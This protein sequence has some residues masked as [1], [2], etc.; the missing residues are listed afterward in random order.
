M[1]SFWK[2]KVPA[3]DMEVIEYTG[4]NFKEVKEL[5]GEDSAFVSFQA[6][7]EAYG[8]RMYV[9]NFG[10]RIRIEVGDQIGLCVD[11]TVKVMSKEF[12]ETHYEPLDPNDDRGILDYPTD[13]VVSGINR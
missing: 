5:I 3:R 13:D 1:T 12:L 9:R 6:G 7:S 10:R 8:G 4:E 2:L 11:R